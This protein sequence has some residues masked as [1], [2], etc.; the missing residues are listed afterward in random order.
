[1]F[2]IFAEY[3]ILAVTFTIAKVTLSFSPPFFLIAFR[4]LYAALLLIGIST[5][6][7]ARILPK[8]FPDATLFLQAGL[9]H[10][11]LAFVPEFWA[12]Q[13]MPSAKV[14]LIFALTPFLATI[15]AFFFANHRFKL[16]EFIGMF[17]GFLS[18]IPL[19]I[20]KQ[21]P[22]GYAQLYNISLPEIVLL[23]AVVSATYAWFV[24]KKLMDKQYA[25]TSINGVAM[26]I[27]SLLSAATSLYSEGVYAYDLVQWPSFLFWVTV[28][29][30]VSHVVSYNLYSYLLTKYSIPFMTFC[31][32]MTPIFA[33][34]LGAYF[35]GESITWHYL[36]AIAGITFGLAVYTRLGSR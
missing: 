30:L 17:I 1:M 13:Y 19:I 28:L 21:E 9:F 4:L 11:F 35:L 14:S 16:R 32:F 22:I 33:S 25:I 20:I 7:G 2:L 27:G 26:G 23:V 31:G 3:F 36:S 18:L 5:I 34:L 12:L 29:V 24:V 6:S 10:A 15:M 8:N